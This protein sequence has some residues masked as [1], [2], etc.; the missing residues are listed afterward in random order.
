M[1]KKRRREKKKKVQLVSNIGVAHITATFNN[2]MVSIS[3]LKGNVLAWSSAGTVGFKGAK[4]ST[5]YA[6]Q[7]AS[8]NVAKHV[9]ELGLKELEV[10]VKGPGPGRESAIRSLQAAGLS[11]KKVRDI[12]PM[13]HNGCRPKKRRRV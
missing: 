11:V 2:T 5:P 8:M 3:D 1:A 12:T 7:I 9:K 6:A 13:P 4:K 10:L